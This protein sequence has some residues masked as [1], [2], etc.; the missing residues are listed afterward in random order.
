MTARGMCGVLALTSVFG[1]AVGACGVDGSDE[2][3]SPSP[4]QT[5]ASLTPPPTPSSVGASPPTA[6]VACAN[7]GTVAQPQSTYISAT[8][9]LATSTVP[10]HCR[11]ELTVAPAIK[12]VV[13][14]PDAWNG[15]FQAIGGGGFAGFLPDVGP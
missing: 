1:C 6:G 2:F 13:A 11:V 10:A 15:K 5:L 4:R 14:L 12:V 3:P 7:L 9:V 8:E